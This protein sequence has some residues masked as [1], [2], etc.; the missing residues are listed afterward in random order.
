MIKARVVYTMKHMWQ[1]MRLMS[2]WYYM[3]FIIGSLFVLGALMLVLSVPL[4]CLLTHNSLPAGYVMDIFIAV[5]MAVTVLALDLWVFVLNHR[6]NYRKHRMKYGN[7]PI[8]FE[9][10]EDEI[11]VEAKT[12]GFE[13][14]LRFS[15]DK[16][17]RAVE[18][19]DYFL[20]SPRTLTAYVIGK[21]EI[22]EG[23]TEQLRMILKN[24][25]GN[26]FKSKG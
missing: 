26:K 2:I 17:D 8:L 23:S 3:I 10:S 14:F 11:K 22:T 1:V 19:N 9:I 15:F 4:L 18:T 16:L 6:R 13:E 5:L 7:M 12:D 21:N 20:L 24:K 25:M